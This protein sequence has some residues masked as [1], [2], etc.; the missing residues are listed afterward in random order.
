MVLV[1]VACEQ[2]E[3]GGIGLRNRAAERVLIDGADLEILEESAELGG[4]DVCHRPMM[5]AITIGALAPAIFHTIHEA[6]AGPPLLTFLRRCSCAGCTATIALCGSFA[7]GGLRRSATA[8]ESEVDQDGTGEHQNEAENTQD[9]HRHR[10]AGQQ[11]TEPTERRSAAVGGGGVRPQARREL[12]ILCI[13][14]LFHL[15]EQT[16]L[17]L[18]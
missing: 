5:S 8:S 6:A 10:H 11:H 4:N 3:P 12:R 9:D 16:L 13:E 7:S 15:L 17:M 1:R 2:G 14:G 18:R